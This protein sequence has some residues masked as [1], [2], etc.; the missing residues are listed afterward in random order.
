LAEE[1]EIGKLAFNFPRMESEQG[2][3]DV[4]ENAESMGASVLDQDISVMKNQMEKDLKG[5]QFWKM[6]LFLALFF[7]LCE[8]AL[9]R[10]WK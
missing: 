6:A 10:W 4:K 9:I 2:F 1:K 8:M 5:T 7:L 3:L